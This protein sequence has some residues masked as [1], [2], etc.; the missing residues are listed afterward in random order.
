M[1][2]YCVLLF[3]VQNYK[4]QKSWEAKEK[5]VAD[6]LDEVD[7]L[8]NAF[9]NEE[10]VDSVEKKIRASKQRVL[11]EEVASRLKEIDAELAKTDEDIKKEKAKELTQQLD[12]AKEADAV[13][14]T[15]PTVSGRVI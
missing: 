5:E 13:G 14:T 9:V 15:V 6:I 3:A 7:M 4:V 1:G 10:W 12:S 11:L 2:M 8:R